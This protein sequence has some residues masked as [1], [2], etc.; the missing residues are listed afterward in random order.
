MPGSA[1]DRAIGTSDFCN[2]QFLE[3]K[4]LRFL[5]FGGFCRILPDFA[6]FCRILEISTK[7]P[8]FQ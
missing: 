2:F 7:V 5:G 6:G 1:W 4:F 8:Q 3:K